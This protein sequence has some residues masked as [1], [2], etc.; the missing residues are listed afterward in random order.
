MT[1]KDMRDKIKKSE[2]KHEICG[3]NYGYFCE[4][5]KFLLW[6][7]NDN[8][9]YVATTH[10][11]APDVDEG[12]GDPN[13]ATRIGD[14]AVYVGML[15]GQ[16]VALLKTARQGHKTKDEMV[17][18]LKLFPNAEFLVSVGI[19]SGFPQEGV[20]LGDVIVSDVIADHGSARLNPNSQTPRGL[21]HEVDYKIMRIFSSSMETVDEIQVAKDCKQQS[22]EIKQRY[23]QFKKG[24]VVSSFNLIDNKEVRDQV[25]QAYKDQHP[26]AGEMEGSILLTL[27]K[28]NRSVIII[29][30]ITDFADGAKNKAW[31]VM[32]AMAAFHFLK[33]Q[34]SQ[35]KGKVN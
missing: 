4:R 27:K 33:Y 9:Y 29:K 24:L 2:P 19:C 31:Q 6:T 17:E 23:S 34:L 3:V 28:H 25:H 26:L 16:C 7:A 20:E 30:G 13:K 18:Y 22:G 8:E 11:K 35:I 1:Y 21:T 32:S 5:V 10:I 12:D 14:G 15:A